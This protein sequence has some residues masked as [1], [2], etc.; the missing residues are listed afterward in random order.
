MRSRRSWVRIYGSRGF[1]GRSQALDLVENRR[2]DLS[3]WPP[4][5]LPLAFREDDRDLVLLAVEADVGA[6]DVVDDDGVE[7]LA[8][9]LRASALDGPVA[10]LSGE[11]DHGL[12]RSPAGGD[13]GH[14]VLG[15]LELER[16]AS[17]LPD[18]LALA[19]L[20]RPEVG[21]SG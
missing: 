12:I 8:R 20:R 16:E 6:G 13:A 2:G 5:Y 15:G 1:R 17:A 14:D 19:H 10:V 21:G 7:A 4:S 11:A 18:E 3:L 9:E